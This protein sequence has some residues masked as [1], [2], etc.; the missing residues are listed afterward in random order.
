[1]DVVLDNPLLVAHPAKAG[2]RV[3]WALVGLVLLAN[4]LFSGFIYGWS[5]LLLFLLEE[6]QYN[7]LCKPSER[8]CPAQENRLNLI[9]GVAQFVATLSSL[10]VGVILDTIG[11]PSMTAIGGLC[12][13]LGLALLAVADSRSF[14]AFVPAYTLLGVGGIATLL[15]SFRAGFVLLRWQTA[16]LAGVN[17]LYDA[18]A[19][20]PSLLFLLHESYGL[21]RRELLLG[22]ACL[23]ASTYALLLVLWLRHTRDLRTDAYAVVP[24]DADV[25]AEAP[26]KISLSAQIRTFEF[27]YLLLFAGVHIFRAAF[28]FGTIDETLAAFGDTSY[29]YTKAFGWILPAGFVFVPVINGVVEAHSVAASMHLTTALGVL[30]NALAMVPILALQPATFVLF[31]GFR[32]FLYSNVATCAARTFGATHLGTLMGAIYTCSALFAFLEIPAAAVALASAAGR[33]GMYSASLA[34]GL[35]LVPVTEVYRKRQLRA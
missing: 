9:Y 27:R 3:A 15:T 1:M 35:A 23:A 2:N 14:D 4:L 26:T 11:A 31:T 24:S 7:E 8:T 30:S 25:E 16:I 21:S 6:R 17:C 18:S 13:T 20:M 5:S 10:P 29:A 32:A 33:I 28:F 22:C 19:V 34:L 12:T